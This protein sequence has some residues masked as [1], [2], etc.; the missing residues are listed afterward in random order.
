VQ[1]G[2]FTQLISEAELGQG[3]RA[4][5]LAGGR[6]QGIEMVA[7]H[8]LVI[9]GDIAAARKS[10]SLVMYDAENEPIRRFYLE[11]AWPAK[12]SLDFNDRRHLQ[13]STVQLLYESIRVQGE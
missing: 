3:P 5:T 10:C 1:I 9:L 12:V 11:K 4:I 7:W 6:T 13:I 2:V 8:E